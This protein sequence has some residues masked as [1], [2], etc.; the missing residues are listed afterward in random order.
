MAVVVQQERAQTVFP[1]ECRARYTCKERSRIW[2]ER[3][4]E[5]E[6]VERTARL[7]QR[8][9][10]SLSICQSRPCSFHFQTPVLHIRRI[11]RVFSQSSFLSG[12][13]RRRE[14]AALSIKYTIGS[15]EGPL[16]AVC[17]SVFGPRARERRTRRDALAKARLEISKQSASLSKR[18]TP[19]C[20]FCFPLSQR[21]ERSGK[22]S[23]LRCS[24]RPAP[25]RRP[26]CIVRSRT[27]RETYCVQKTRF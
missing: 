19:F 4:R 25:S 21:R 26:E 16:G 23:T 17:C 22:L 18:P 11:A 20:L 3:E 2:R 9:F 27:Y 12:A 10:R 7:L 15:K 13:V 6:R 5:R 8:T 1:R 14:F 24:R